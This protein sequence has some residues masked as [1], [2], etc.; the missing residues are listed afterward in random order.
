MD[1]LQEAADEKFERGL[2]AHILEN[3]AA[4]VVRTPELESTVGELPEETLHSL[5]KISIDRAKSF[6]LTYQSSISAFSALMFEV[7]PNFDRHN[8]CNICLKDQSVDANDRIDEILKL[9][10]EE[11][12]ENIRSDYDANAWNATSDDLE[13]TSEESTPEEVANP[14]F[15]QTAMNTEK[16]E[17]PP[18]KQ[19]DFAE[20][21]INPIV[22]KEPAQPVPDEDLNFLDTV[23]NID[24]SKE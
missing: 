24:T 14:D 2:A 8:L 9:L 17:K 21:V 16:V 10:T 23:L 7:A 4:A 20:T 12:W 13:N 22:A 11:H 3:Y 19:T 18:P 15:A 1:S 6:E 5:I